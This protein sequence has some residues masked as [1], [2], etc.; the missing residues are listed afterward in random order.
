MYPSSASSNE[1][2]LAS[3]AFGDGT[4]QTDLS[5]PGLR[6]GG[7]MAKVEKALSALPDV[8]YARVNLTTKRVS[9]RWSRNGD[10]PDIVGVLKSAGFTANLFAPDQ[11]TTERELTR[12]LRALAVAGFCSMNI[13]MLSI[14]VWLG[15]DPHTRHA[16]HV[17]SAALALP[18]IVY[19]GRIF[20][21]SAWSA[22][23][24]GKTNMDVPISIGVALAFAMS[25]YDTM[26]NASHAYFDAATSLLF[27]LLAGRTLDH[28]MREKARSAVAG[29]ARLVPS[30]AMLAKPDGSR[31]YVPLSEITPGDYVVVAPGDRIPVDGIVIA[32]RSDI[33]RSLVTGESTPVTVLVGGH[34]EAGLL[35]LTGPLTIEVTALAEDSFITEM[36][37]MMEAAEGGRAAYRRLADRA[38]AFYSPVVHGLALLSFVG[39]FLVTGD[40]HHSTTIAIAVLIIT[41]PCALG[42]AVPMVQVVA[43]GR[44]FAHGIMMREGSALERL[45][46]VDA[47]TFDKTGV[48]TRGHMVVRNRNEIPRDALNVAASI[49]SGSRHPTAVAVASAG[50]EAAARPRISA[51]EEYPGLG[52][53]ATDALGENYRLGRPDWATEYPSGVAETA[54]VSVA[55]LSKE[56]RCLATFMLEDDMRPGAELAVR[57]LAD[58]N[59][60]CEILSGDRQAVVQSVAKQLGVARFTAEMSPREKIAR[61]KLLTS[62]GRKVLMVGDGMNDLPALSA[63]HV[64]MAP[65]TAVDI[66]RNSADFVFLHDDLRAVPEAMMV[67]SRAAKLIRQNFGLAVAYNVLAVPVAVAGYV[68]PLLAALA[69]SLSS[70][71]VVANALRLHELPWEQKFARFGTMA[72]VERS[73]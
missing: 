73:A 44:L 29:L 69:M 40:W 50:E 61:I 39:W 3:R 32:G 15:A 9:V 11:K 18:A 37:R 23:R 6:C 64:S 27:F 26:H 16:F 12:L 28:L 54:A 14:A 45:A 1:V 20:Y 49:A 10:I 51:R 63:A 43:A 70:M 72:L 52:I 34:V 67:A 33:D 5:V 22:I 56:G 41:C 4:Y 53:E 25:M 19:S 55:V 42:L 68:T 38:S 65:A 35:N 2:L 47:V 58:H 17:M 59:T 66:G 30:A 62:A 71:V 13:M 48:L 21:Q 46:E 31:E 7:C 24:H 8:S 36:L 57:T 60:H